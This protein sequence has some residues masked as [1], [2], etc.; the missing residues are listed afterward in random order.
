MKDSGWT[1]RS[2][3]WLATKSQTSVGRPRRR[4]RGDIM[5]QQEGF[6]CLLLNVP[7]TCECIAGTDL[8]RQFT[9]CHTEIEVANQ[10]FHH[11]QLQHT[12]TGP[13]TPSTDPIRQATGVP[14]LLL[15]LLGVRRLHGQHCS[16]H[17]AIFAIT[18]S[19]GRFGRTCSVVWSS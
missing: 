17:S 9:C 6:V 10:T 1:T 18:L 19:R 13:T 12:D 8:L 16:R 7:V 3:G 2:T 5:R 4:W 15:L 14:R 11:T